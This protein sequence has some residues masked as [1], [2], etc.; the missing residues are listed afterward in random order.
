MF[1]DA[2][3]DGEGRLIVRGDEARPEVMDLASPGCL[4]AVLRRLHEEVGVRGVV[5]VRDREQAYGPAA[6]AALRHL[7]VLARLLAR[8]AER[9][10]APDFPGYTAKE[11]RAVCTKCT[12]RP[13]TMFGRLAETVLGGD[14]AAFV[15]LLKEVAEGLDAYAEGGCRACTAASRADLHLVLREMEGGG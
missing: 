9:P 4:A 13:S 10:P 8:F 5:L 12:F 7:L 15:T 6:L 3:V 2:E 14:P 1:E 11:V